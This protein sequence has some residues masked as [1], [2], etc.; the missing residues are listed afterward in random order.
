MRVL[1][2]EETRLDA[3][4][5]QQLLLS[6]F[7]GTFQFTHAQQ[8]AEAQENVRRFPFDLCLWSWS[9]RSMGEASN[10]LQR[11]VETGLPVV[12][13]V[14]RLD[15]AQNLELI[16]QG[17]QDC[18]L[19]RDLTPSSLARVMHFAVERHQHEIAAWKQRRGAY[20][21]N[22]SHQLRTPL[23]AILGFSEMLSDQDALPA[24]AQAQGEAIEQAGSRMLAMVDDVL[25]FGRLEAGLVEVTPEP[26][27]LH[28]LFQEVALA[29][30][31]EARAKGLQLDF[32]VSQALP[33]VALTDPAKLRHIVRNL[34]SNA[35]RF[36]D[37][38]K[39]QFQVSMGTCEG[40]DCQICAEV[41]DSGI[42]IAPSD[43]DRIFQPFEQVSTRSGPGLGLA[44]CQRLAT[45]L[46]GNVRVQ[47]E[48]GKGSLFALDLNVCKVLHQPPQRVQHFERPKSLAGLKALIVDDSPVN[49]KLLS[50]RLALS[51]MVTVEAEDGATALALM[52][53]EMPQVVLMD[54]RMPGMDGLE[55]TLR[56]KSSAA[57]K[58][59]PVIL[60]TACSFQEDRHLVEESGADAF[61]R[62]PVK[63]GELLS[64][65]EQ[66]L[67][68]E[69]S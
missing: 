14:N 21:A 65:L 46:G 39:V 27:H 4:A 59:V 56:I 28:Q 18:L 17:A 11:L 30:L 51:G 50:L 25:E 62:K 2:I 53:Q 68:V 67:E 8:L 55:A 44:I 7:P 6:S 26:C 12:L 5:L 10:A 42:G 37:V 38:G 52:D 54:R 40:L 69:A 35:I 48:L 3:I 45:L 16:A 64:A 29:H 24:W 23:N 33:Q 60:V 19:K 32:E 1:L 58:E 61:L 20:L 15:Q 47:S 22:I 9:P 31:P 63:A 34:L 43:F 49:R 36:T 41:R 66:C 57:V 13:L